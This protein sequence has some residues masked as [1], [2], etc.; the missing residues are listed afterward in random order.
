MSELVYPQ[1]SYKITGILFRV[2]NELGGGYQE[3]YYQKAISAELIKQGISFQEQIAVKLNY[4]QIKIGQYFIDFV[5]DDK[6]VLEIKAQSKFYARDIKQVLGYLKSSNKKLG[7][8]AS[9]ARNGL[10]FK[11][12]LKGSR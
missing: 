1:L 3:K 9:F 4:S 11:R 10:L 2:Y 5:I 7:I 8:L 12:I 6:I